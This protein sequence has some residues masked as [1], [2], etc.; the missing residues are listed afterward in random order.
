LKWLWGENGGLEDRA[1]RLV[2]DP[3]PRHLLAGGQRQLFDR[4]H[5]PDVVGDAG[6]GRGGGRRPPGRGGPGVVP[7][8]PPLDRARARQ[9]LARVEVGQLDVQAAGAP[10]RVVSVEAED[11][12]QQ[13]RRVRRLVAPARLVGGDEGR[14]ADVVPA[15][16][17]DPD[18]AGRDAQLV[19]DGGR[20]ETLAGQAKDGP[21]DAG[22]MRLRH[23]TPEQSPRETDGAVILGPAA[24]AQN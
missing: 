19:G 12:R 16:Q 15:A 6:A 18:G 1:G 10:A 24:P 11:D 4:V 17:Q 8:Q 9:R 13:R 20:G 22:R 7:A 5:L 21:A 3:Q 14:R 2:G 23:G